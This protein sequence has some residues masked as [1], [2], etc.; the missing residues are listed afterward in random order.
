VPA[1]LVS[2][3]VE[4][5]RVD[6]T[7][8]E[9]SS[10]PATIKTLFHLPQGLTA[11]DKAANTFEKNLTR[12]I[13]RND[14]PLT[15]PIPGDAEESRR[16]RA[17]LRTDAL[18]RWRRGEVDPAEMSREP[19]STFQEALVDLAHLLNEKA[20]AAPHTEPIRTEHEA[21]LHIHQSLANFLER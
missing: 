7:I 1:I 6:S 20:H 4:K 17:W 9:H 11:R 14:T 13:P 10:L 18:D 12:T 16:H 15:L 5:G 8:Y 21:A 2:P 19:L 3:Y